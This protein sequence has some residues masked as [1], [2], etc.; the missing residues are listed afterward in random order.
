MIE[1]A[2]YLPLNTEDLVKISGFGQVKIE[3]YGAQFITCVVDY[4]KGRNLQSR[5]HE[6]N[7]K[8][9]RKPK[10]E[11]DNETKQLTLK[12]FLEGKS[13]NQIALSRNLNKSTIETHLAFYIREGKITVDRL[14]GPE[15]Y[16][17][18]RDAIKAH[19]AK[20]LGPI[21][22][23]LGEGYTYGEIRYVLAHLEISKL[24][25]AEEIYGSIKHEQKLVVTY[26]EDMDTE[27]K[28]DIY[29]VTQEGIVRAA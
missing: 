7:P 16:T 4:C 19:G 23:S 6:K 1:L 8:R 3:K 24:E 21:K 28:R 15:K 20:T 13:V 2:K 27:K 25:E 5:I 29:V 17:V 9:I 14:L 18:I 26:I 11:R 22:E 10:I 12:L